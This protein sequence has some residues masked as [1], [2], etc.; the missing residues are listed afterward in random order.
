MDRLFWESPDGIGVTVQRTEEGLCGE[1]SHVTLRYNSTNS[2]LE[3]TSDLLTD[4]LRMDYDLNKLDR[5]VRDDLEAVAQL[6]ARGERVV[7]STPSNVI[8]DALQELEDW[9]EE[10]FPEEEASSKDRAAP[11]MG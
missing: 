10:P 7:R 9:I 5:D 11:V 3:L 2:T 1:G 8:P 4:P 6:V